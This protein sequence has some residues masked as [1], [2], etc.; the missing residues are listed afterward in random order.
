MPLTTSTTGSLS[1]S[2]IN[3]EIFPNITPSNSYN[4]YNK[5]TSN[6]VSGG[7]TPVITG[8]D[9]T[10]TIQ[11]IT[12]SVSG[13]VAQLYQSQRIQDFNQFIMTF[14]VSMT[15]T[16]IFSYTNDGFCLY[17]GATSPLTSMTPGNGAVG[18]VFQAIPGGSFPQGLL[19]NNGFF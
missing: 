4:W 7:Y 11:L 10:K 5:M 18:F 17:F 2:Q 12:T 15:G 16:N 1:L 8:S 6:T 9:P 3:G 19:F 14:N 13:Q